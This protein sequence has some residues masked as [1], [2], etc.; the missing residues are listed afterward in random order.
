MPVTINENQQGIFVAL[1]ATSGTYVAPTAAAFLQTLDLKPAFNQSDK[2][3]VNLDGL[4][5]ASKLSFA[6][7]KHHKLPF[8]VALSWPAGAPTAT[9]NL[10]AVT[11]LLRICGSAAPVAVAATTIAPIVPAH[12]RY[13]EVNDAS[14]GVSASISHRRTRSTTKHY[15]RQLANAR[16]AVKF[17]WK[18]GEIPQFDFDI[19]GNWQAEIESA[20]LAGAPGIQL[21]NIA[22]PSN[23]LNTLNV[24]LNGKSLCA[25]EI[26][27]DNVFRMKTKVIESLCGTGAIAD[28][29][30]DSKITVT[31]RKP[32]IV[33]EF[34]PDTYWGNVYPFTFTIKGDG[35][36]STRSLVFSWAS[37]QV[38]AVEETA[39]DGV[40]HNKLTLNKTSPLLLQLF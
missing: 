16:G 30:E 25:V 40:V 23:A 4:G 32:D 26:N 24:L 6:S 21:T 36:L 35:A 8:K 18:A 33:T 13:Q 39:V 17:A 9:T 11:P 31:F 22:Q 34:A 7:K 15:E 14:A 5:R 3:T 2:K 28:P 38:D 19:V 29:A 27:D 1:E 37:V 12:V 10:L 20:A